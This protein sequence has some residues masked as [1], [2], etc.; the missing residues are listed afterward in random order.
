VARAA[1]TSDSFNAIAE[2]RRR[3]I[4]EL[5]CE[6]ERS[7]NDVAEALDLDQPAVSKHLRVLREVRLVSVRKD[8]RHR[9]YAA[10]PEALEPVRVWIAAIERFWDHKLGRIRHMAEEK[11]RH[12]REGRGD[13]R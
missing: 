7:V 4:F 1:T 11:A 8:G 3:A 13:S 12:M 5:L 10:C 2:P 9:Y 6:S